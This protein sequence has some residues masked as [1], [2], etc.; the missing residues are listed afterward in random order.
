MFTTLSQTPPTITTN[1][2][3]NVTSTGATLNGT[4]NP[5]EVFNPIGGLVPNGQGTTVHFEYGTTTSY[6][7]TTPNQ[8]FTGGKTQNVMAS[9]SSLVPGTLYHFRL[10]GTN[11]GGT[12]NGSDLTFTTVQPAPT[13]TTAAA[14]NV[15]TTA[16]ALN[17]MV[18]PN[19][20]M[21]TTV[22]FEYGIT[23][24]YGTSTSNQMFTGT[25]NQNVTA[26]ISGLI[27]NTLYHF[28]LVGSN[29]GG[30]TNGNDLTFMTAV[31][32]PTPTPSPCPNTITQST[33]QL[34]E[35]N[36]SVA[37][38]S[39][40]TNYHK[41]NSYWRAF[42]MQTF[43]GG[44]AFTVNSVSFGV[45]EATAGPSPRPA[46]CGSPNPATTQPVDVRLYTTTAAGGAFPG[47][48]RT[49]LAQTT[50]CLPNMAGGVYVVPLTA[51]IPAGVLEVV[52][53]VHNPT[54]VATQDVF[55]IGSNF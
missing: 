30:T 49:L 9:I 16:A 37:C 6:G 8:I 46:P 31:P 43:T 17:G 19:G 47:G 27:P 33:S 51:T 40:G 41:D 45:Q 21:T 2:A 11:T 25:T 38:V 14:T 28:R 42:N 24:G 10:V 15:T 53:E 44:Q 50:V 12:V 4:V 34:V 39:S 26:N 29:S 54:G 23:T 5:N 13:I 36:N 32:T 52:M 7:S 22:H 55:F 3:T 35:A 1:P 48:Q 18:N 20:A